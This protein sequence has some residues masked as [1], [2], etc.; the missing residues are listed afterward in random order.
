MQTCFR[1]KVKKELRMTDSR[2]ELEELS[3]LFAEPA[4]RRIAASNDGISIP[5][6][7]RDYELVEPLGE[8]GMG[9]VW[10]GRQT[11]PI[12]RKA[13]IKL[14]RPGLFSQEFVRRFEKERRVLARMDH[15]SIPKVF[16]AGTHNGLPFLVMELVNG[17]ALTDHCQENRLN[18]RDRLSL[19]VDTCRAVQHAHEQEVI[20]RDLKPSNVLVAKYDRIASIK[21]IDFGLARF[22]DA[23][24]HEPT[25]EPALST[26]AGTFEYMSPEQAS[27]ESSHIDSRTDVYS[28]GVLLFELLTGTTPVRSGTPPEVS[29]DIRRICNVEPPTPSRLL[30]KRIELCNSFFNN[31]PV[32]TRKYIRILREELDWVVAHAIEKARE[33]RYQTVEELADEVEL[34]LNDKETLARRPTLRRKIRKSISK[35]RM[36]YVGFVALA[37]FFGIGMVFGAAHFAKPPTD[38]QVLFNDRSIASSQ[39]RAMAF[40]RFVKEQRANPNTDFQSMT[41]H[42]NCLGKIGMYN[43][44]LQDTSFTYDQDLRSLCLVKANMQNARLSNSFFGESVLVSADMTNAAMNGADFTNADLTDANCKGTNFHNAAFIGASLAGCDLTGARLEGACLAEIRNWMGAKIGDANLERAVVDASD[45]LS[46]VSHQ[47]RDPESLELWVVKRV[48][49]DVVLPDERYRRRG[50]SYWIQKAKNDIAP[51][52]LGA[53]GTPERE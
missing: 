47:V 21:V 4:F 5:K 3:E 27:L 35:N 52:R 42:S 17:K 29:S 43:V 8:G 14:I 53:V 6:R 11:E 30:Q 45:W 1:L 40:T 38:S 39:E 46:H 7:I 50:Y 41:T 16:E 37:V 23:S 12:E 26:G 28:L 10:L 24:L 20:H 32:S 22:A 51:R 33:D 13:A 49:K 19:F 36:H 44:Q 18:L 31:C 2:G 34:F 15:P 9:S 48:P 25:L